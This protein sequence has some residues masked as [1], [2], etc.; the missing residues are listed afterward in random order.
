MNYH[1][2]RLTAVFLTFAIASTMAYAQGG[3]V[4][5][6]GAFPVGG[7]SGAGWRAGGA[8]AGGG[9]P[10]GGL[11]GAGYASGMPSAPGFGGYVPGNGGMPGQGFVTYGGIPGA[12]TNWS[13]AHPYGWYNGHWH[14]HWQGYGFGGYTP[15]TSASA[16]SAPWDRFGTGTGMGGYQ[17]GNYAGGNYVG[18][19]YGSGN[20]ASGNYGGGN[21]PPS[22]GVGGWGRGSQW[23]NSGYTAYYNP[24]NDPAV[25]TMF[26]YG[27]PIPAPVGAKLADTDNP[28]AGLAIDRFRAADYANALSLIDGVIRIQPYDAAAHELRGLILFAMKNYTAAAATIHSVLATGPGWDWTTLSSV[29]SDMHQYESQLTELENYVA[30]HPRQGSAR[31]LLAYHYIT[32]GRT[33]EAKEQLEQVIALVPKDKLAA[34]LLRMVGGGDAQQA[35]APAAAPASDEKSAEPAA[36]AP[37]VKPADPTTFVGNWHAKRDDGATF[38]L[39]LAADKTFTWKFTQQ[40]QV[41]TM[42]GT[43]TL[44]KTT[45]TLHGPN[46]GAMVAEVNTDGDN[47]FTFKPLGGPSVDPGLTFVK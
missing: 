23:Y 21:Y 47:R 43:Y 18:G 38:D 2:Y 44:D 45:L 5:Y 22:W 46:Q 14:N 16:P 27:R 41:Q 34:R 39:K 35:V 10:A 24:Y 29:Y 42:T 30:S 4:F 20:Y 6:G 32:A 26:N 1:A 36:P 15:P 28:E 37:D 19:T 13:Y 31:F 3:G 12:A 33:E 40:D 9:W 7:V 17:G 8:I 11:P 25:T